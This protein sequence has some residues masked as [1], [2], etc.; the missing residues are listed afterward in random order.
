MQANIGAYAFIVNGSDDFF[1]GASSGLRS[2]GP[3]GRQRRRLRKVMSGRGEVEDEPVR[4]VAR[5]S[6]GE[7]AVMLLLRQGLPAAG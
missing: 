5:P 6:R 7:G 3:S 2:M 4:V 1:W